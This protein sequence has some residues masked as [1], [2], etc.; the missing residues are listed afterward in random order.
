MR[1]NK[2]QLGEET[3][4]KF[5]EMTEC[6][7]LTPYGSHKVFHLD[8]KRK[9]WSKKIL[10][11]QDNQFT[12]RKNSSRLTLIV[13]VCL[14]NRLRKLFHWQNNHTMKINSSNCLSLMPLNIQ[15]TYWFS[16][17]MNLCLKPANFW[18]Y[19]A[20]HIKLTK[21]HHPLAFMTVHFSLCINKLIFWFY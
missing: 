15:I 9:L 12:Q 11:E 10:K 21:R 2:L 7:I 5:W 8:I 20:S 4:R 16:L 1:D 3:L 18:F 17:D 19:S 6:L 14:G 13:L